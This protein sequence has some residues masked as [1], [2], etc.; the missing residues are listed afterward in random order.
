MYS[1]KHLA[2]ETSFAVGRRYIENASGNTIV[3]AD[4]RAAIFRDISPV[5][6]AELIP[7]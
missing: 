2:R 5:I 1:L 4:L 3:S 6:S 7:V